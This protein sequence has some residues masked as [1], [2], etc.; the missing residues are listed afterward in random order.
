[1]LENFLVFVLVPA[2]GQPLTDCLPDRYF[3][4]RS[5]SDRMKAAHCGS[6]KSQSSHRPLDPKC[7]YEVQALTSASDSDIY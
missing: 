6:H 4:S 5:H 3:S 1:M 7:A 2:A